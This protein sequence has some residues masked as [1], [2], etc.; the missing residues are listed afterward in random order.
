MAQL[1]P[2][3]YGSPPYGLPQPPSAAQGPPLKDQGLVYLIAAF[4]GLYGIDRFYLGQIGLG[5]AKLLTGGGLGI[6][7]IID[8]ILTGTG[9]MRDADGNPLD[10]GPVYGTPT[11]SQSV[12]FI[13]SYFLGIFGI[14]RFYLG[15][16]GLGILKLLTCGG[17]LGWAMIDSIFIGMGKMRDAEGNSLLFDDR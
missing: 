15:Y 6:W 16:T 10:H 4:L 12:A 1:T 8:V 5:V 3:G 7:A 9:K 17:L 14:D 13:L 2:P 11:R